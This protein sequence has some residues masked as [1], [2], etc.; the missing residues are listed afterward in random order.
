MNWYK[1][2][3]EAPQQLEL[4]IWP[5][6]N[7]TRKVV[8]FDF[9]ST[10]MFTTWDQD[11]GD[12]IMDEMTGEPYGELNPAIAQ[13]I[14]EYSSQGWKVILVTSRKIEDLESAELFCKSH[15]LP[16]EEY[17][18]TNGYDKVGTLLELGVSVHFDDD[19]HELSAIQ[20]LGQGQIEGFGP[21]SF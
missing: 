14:Q 3:L 9:D 21:E 16:I 10:I 8:S 18:A 15:G 19:D 20:E 6:E 5:P 11:S 13:K 1:T 12:F 4:G 7:D 17:Y 2:A